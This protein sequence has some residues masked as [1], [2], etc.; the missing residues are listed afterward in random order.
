M[1]REITVYYNYIPTKVIID[2]DT[3]VVPESVNSVDCSNKRLTRLIVSKSVETIWCS[4]NR[5]K[6]LVLPDSIKQ[7]DCDNNV[8]KSFL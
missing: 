2:N 3:L 6:E 1:K 4:D 7:L 5:L 8:K